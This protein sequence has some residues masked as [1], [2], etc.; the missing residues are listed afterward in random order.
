[1]ANIELLHGRSVPV[2]RTKRRNDN[3]FEHVVWPYRLM[4]P[5]MFVLAAYVHTKKTIFGLF[6]KR[7]RCNSLI[8]DGISI[9]SRRVKDGAAK[10]PALDACYNFITGEGSNVLIRTVDTFWMQIRNAQAVRNRLKIVRRELRRAIIASSRSD[11]PVRI[12]SLAAG[13][14]Q[15]VL[16]VMAELRAQGYPSEA[17]LVDRDRTA[18]EYARQLTAFHGLHDSV[19]IVEGDVTSFDK[20]TK[21]YRPHIIEMCGLMDY[22][23]DTLAE[24]LVRKIRANLETGGFFLT[25]HIHPNAETYF[26]RHVVDWDMLYRPLEKFEDILTKG[27]FLDARYETE[28]HRIHTVAIGRK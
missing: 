18:L 5:F 19:R 2:T 3:V 28:P 27:N 21:G 11:E 6:E 23:R 14:A 15:G 13:T 8:V 9:N 17:V 24:K 16:E 12:L 26:L 4:L 1:M 25:C 22:L 10:W 7:V 20:L